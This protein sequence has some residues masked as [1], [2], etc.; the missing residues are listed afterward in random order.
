VLACQDSRGIHAASLI[1]GMLLAIDAL[2][3]LVFGFIQ[4]ALPGFGDVAVVL[5]FVDRLALGDIFIM[6]LVTGGLPPGHGTVRE[7]LVDAR[8]LIVE[9]L[10][11]HVLA[12][13]VRHRS[14][15]RHRLCADQ[16][17]A[18]EPSNVQKKPISPTVAFQRKL[19][20]PGI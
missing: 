16:R 10:I 3:V 8:L 11:D 6:F 14:G 1:L 19:H 20:R 13:M 4:T 7:A 5:G 9:P 18:R 12:R 2:T 17:G 15:L